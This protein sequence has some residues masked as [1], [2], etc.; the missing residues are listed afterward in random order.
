M[1]GLGIFEY[2]CV[3]RRAERLRILI[4]SVNRDPVSASRHPAVSDGEETAG[5]ERHSRGG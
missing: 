2:Y 4:M 1:P 5:S 3:I